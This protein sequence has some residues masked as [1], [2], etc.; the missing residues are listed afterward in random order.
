[1][2]AQVGAGAWTTPS[3]ENQNEYAPL[4]PEELDS[5][6]APIALYPDA[7]VAQVLGAATF[8]DQVTDANGWLKR[9]SR[10]TGEPLMRA[11]EKES[12]DPAVRALTLFPSVLDDLAKNLAWT[13]ALGEAAASQQQDVMAAIQRCEQKLTRRAT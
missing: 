11:V 9:N 6:V 7:L 1:M 5:L 2:P 8:P 3:S 12:W 4:I 13:S 10:L